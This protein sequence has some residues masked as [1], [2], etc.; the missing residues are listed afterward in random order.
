MGG[1]EG[2]IGCGGRCFGVVHIAVAEPLVLEP[3]QW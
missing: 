1:V 3:W 2:G